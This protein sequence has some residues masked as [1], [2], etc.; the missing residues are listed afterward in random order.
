[1]N[2]LMNTTQARSQVFI[3]QDTLSHICGFLSTQKEELTAREVCK[4]WEVA[5]TRYFFNIYSCGLEPKLAPY[6]ACRKITYDQYLLEKGVNPL[7]PS[8]EAIFRE[9][10][11]IEF[12]V[13]INQCVAVGDIPQISQIEQDMLDLSV[14]DEFWGTNL[15]NFV[16][17]LD[18]NKMSPELVRDHDQW[19]ENQRRILDFCLT[20]V[21]TIAEFLKKMQGMPYITLQELDS[22]P[23][24]Q[25]AKWAGFSSDKLYYNRSKRVYD[26]RKYNQIIYSIAKGKPFCG[27]FPIT[28]FDLKETDFEKDLSGQRQLSVKCPI[29]QRFC[30]PIDGQLCEFEI[31]SQKK[32]EYLDDNEESSFDSE[33]ELG[34]DEELIEIKGE[35]GQVTRYIE[36]NDE[37]GYR[38]IEEDRWF[39]MFSLP[40]A[41]EDESHRQV[42]ERE[43]SPSMDW[44]SD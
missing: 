5:I 9:L 13:S 24:S 41:I 34:S 12:E 8:I 14:D 20:A 23:L 19:G 36:S 3:C 17:H 26:E 16:K 11:P 30:F 25:E 42:K 27:S 38:R 10:I 37:P 35:S 7:N 18:H 32:R 1:M 31:C 29:G 40:Y 22:R 28:F 21:S 2:A 33:V 43:R 6:L 15:F 4:E 44:Q 39:L